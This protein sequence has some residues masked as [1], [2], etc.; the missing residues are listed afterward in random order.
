MPK[1]D[2]LAILGYREEAV[3]HTFFRQ[4]APA[5]HLVLLFP[6]VGY[7]AHM[8]LLYY[9]L[10]LA[11]AHGADVLRVETVYIHNPD[12]Q[13]LTQEEQARWVQADALAACRAGL[14]QGSYRRVTLVGK[15]LGTLA[16]MHVL[17][18]QPNLPQLSCI[19]L[20]PIL[21]SS[22][23]REV[24]RR[25]PQRALFVIGTADSYYNP[26]TLHDLEQASGGESL[27]IPHADHSLEL[28]GDIPASLH[29]LEKI[30]EKVDQF[31]F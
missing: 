6:G 22:A 18:A 15:S 11:L 2:T 26:Q 23:L 8:P 30:M 10:Q 14:A 29:E 25:V 1:F 19:W 3:P 17:A 5:G 21:S 7:T 31:L 28:P 20:T 24:I 4:E 9:T 12:Y 13:A 16:M 27:V